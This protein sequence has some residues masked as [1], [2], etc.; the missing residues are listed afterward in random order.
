ELR[1]IDKICDAY[2][3]DRSLKSNQFEIVKRSVFLN[4]LCNNPQK[5]VADLDELKSDLVRITEAIT[6]IPAE[7]IKEHKI[8][9]FNLLNRLYEMN[10]NANI[11]SVF[12]KA[13]C[14]IDLGLYNI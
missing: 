14:S 11:S 1:H 4:L 5:L 3:K 7:K 2:L 13:V 12:R 9:Y 8:V 10:L 6:H